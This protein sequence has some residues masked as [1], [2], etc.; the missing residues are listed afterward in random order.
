MSSEVIEKKKNQEQQAA[1]DGFFHF[2]FGPEK[3]MGITGPGGVGKTW[4]MGSM[5]DEVM[6]RYY[7]TCKLMDIQ[8]EY[9]SVHMTA[10]T[11]KAAE[12][13]GLAAN[14]PTETIHSFLKLK[15]QDDYSTGKSNLVKTRDFKVHERKIIFIDECSTIDTPLKR[16]IEEGTSKSKIIYVGDHCQLN[17]VMESSSPVFN[18]GINFFHLTQ[19]MRTNNPVLHKL[20]QQLRNT[21]ETGI[22][23]P[24][25]IVPGVVDY[26]NDE[27][28]KKYLSS[29]FAQQTHSSR[30]L[31]FTNARV[32]E[33]ND[34]IR[35][36]RGLP[37]AY[38]QGE[39]LINNASIQLR[40]GRLSVEDEVQILELDKDSTMVDITADAQLEVRKAT[41]QT[42]LG[43]VHTNIMLPVDREHY[44]AL[45]K[46]FAS[47]KVWDRYFFLRNTFPDL[48]QR[49]GSTVDKS[50][51]ST[52]DTVFI[53]LS[54][55]GTCNV[56]NRVAR[57]LYVAVSR[58]RNRV[59]LYGQLP[60]KYGGLMF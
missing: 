8:P 6:P 5:I 39:Y 26:L 3:E 55:I 17:P 12:V 29:E 10:T 14:R 48:R 16:M 37:D 60:E 18:S 38:T 31:A 59:F 20:N 43:D 34:Y 30:V 57:M 11:N 1:V 4:T 21:V 53:D 45:T 9:D 13:L 15:V 44:L 2:L 23:E 54:N 7:Q 28:M 58:A 42:R 25:Q 49:D 41:L 24:I 19:P 47:R 56:P 36:L 50:Q 40:G 35:D 33:Y 27:D 32:I 51:G 22:F 46:Y 52:L